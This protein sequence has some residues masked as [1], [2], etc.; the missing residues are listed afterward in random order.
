M[1]PYLTRD[2]DVIVAHRGSTRYPAL[3]SI[4]ERGGRY[5]IAVVGTDSA[6]AMAMREVYGMVVG[7]GV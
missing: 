3:L 4:W 7:E 6:E 2:G 1:V 5:D